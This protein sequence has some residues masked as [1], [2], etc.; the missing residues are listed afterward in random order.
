[1]TTAPH[2]PPTAR[3]RGNRLGFWFFHAATRLTGLRGAY[4][5]LYLVCPYYLLFDRAAVA[6]ALAY[7]RRRFPGRSG[8]RLRFD[9]LRLFISQGRALIDRHAALVRPGL[10]RI[11]FPSLPLLRDQLAPGRGVVLLLAH[12][13][14]WQLALGALPRIGRA[15]TLVM[16][17]EDN[18]AVAHNLRVNPDG[19][20]L[21]VLAAGAD[22]AGVVG[23][24]QR[25]EAGDVVC[26]MADR[27]YQ[28][29]SAAV[30]F[31]DG[32][33]R[34]PVGPY[35]LARSAGCPVVFLSTHRAA[36]R[37]YVIEA[38]PIPAP[39]ADEG[40]RGEQIAGWAAA[41]AARLDAYARRHPYE[42]FLFHDIWDDDTV[43]KA[44]QK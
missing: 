9:A 10:F 26:L 33:A 11:D 14:N 40:S 2:S 23:I 13:G 19:D 37:H 29:R 35:Q 38:E 7:L 41:F 27:S 20:G 16:R 1:M 39:P 15:V 36:H 17:P 4:G 21:R 30:P 18:P 8:L 24:L 22:A 43:D 28:F 34:M 44:G 3:R 31:L 42:V 25:I 12:V 5:L 32:M 6:G